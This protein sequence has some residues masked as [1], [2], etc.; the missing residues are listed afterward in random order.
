MS[1]T[2][3]W[4]GVDLDGTLAVYNGWVGTEHIGPPVKPMIDRVKR[5]IAEGQTVK[6][7]TARMH[8]HGAPLVGG[9]TCDVITPIQDWCEKHIGTRLEVTNIKDFGM[10]TLYDDRCVQVIPN[11]GILVQQAHHLLTSSRTVKQTKQT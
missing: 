8:G 3:G 10:I 2:S 11:Q 6:I 7:F 5:W 4:I 1:S 9:G